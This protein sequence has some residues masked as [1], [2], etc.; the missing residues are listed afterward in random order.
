ML[1]TTC[2]EVYFH[3]GPL[4]KIKMESLNVGNTKAKF[5]TKYYENL[6]AIY[7][8]NL[9]KKTLR[10]VLVKEFVC[11]NKLVIRNGESCVIK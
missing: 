11:N 8:E 5:D 4:K 2:F 1:R 6:M 9:R 10:I 7:L 3:C